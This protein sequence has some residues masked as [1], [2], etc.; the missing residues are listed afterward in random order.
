MVQFDSLTDMLQ[1]AGSANKSITFIYDEKEEKTVLYRQLYSNAVRMLFYLQS[2]GIG[3]GQEVIL[4][5]NDNEIFL[6]VFW[7]CILGGIIPV[8]VSPVVNDEQKQKLFRIW[9]ILEDPYVFADE[10]V[11]D[12]LLK[13]KADY[14]ME[15]IDAIK[16]KTIYSE[17]A[18]LVTGAGIIYKPLPEDIAFI[19]FSSGSTGN[20]KGVVLTHRNLLVN[21]EDMSKAWNDNTEDSILSWMPLTHDMGMITF[22]IRAI[23]AG[24]N[25]YLIPTSLFIRKPLLW[26]DKVHEHRITI[27]SSPNFGYKY[28]LLHYNQAKNLNTW[29]LSCLRI[30]LNGAEPI[31]AC[32]CEEFMRKMEVYGLKCNSMTP[33]YGLAEATVGVSSNRP[34]EGLSVIYANRKF[35]G[36]GQKIKQT[37]ACNSNS[38][39][40][41]DVGQPF[42]NCQVRI[43]DDRNRVL[44]D[45]Y[46]GYI[47]I[48]GPNVTSGYY[49]NMDATESAIKD[50]WLNTGDLGFVR[51]GRLTITGRAKDIIIINGQNYYPHDIERVAENVKGI[52]LGKIVACG[53]FD[54]NTQKEEVFLFVLHKKGLEKFIPIA[55]EVKK[56]VNRIFGIDIKEVIPIKKIFKTTSGKVQ[57]Y[58]LAEMYSKGAFTGIIQEMDRLKASIAGNRET[59][60]PETN[61]EK[62][63][64]KIWQAVLK[65][66]DIGINENLFEIGG[67]SISVIS[68]AARIHQQFGV[69]IPVGRMF[70]IVTIRSQAE[71]IEASG[72]NSYV[73]IKKAVKRE[74]YP[75]SAAQKGMFI[76]QKLDEESIACNITFA[77]KI[78]GSLEKS[79]LENALKKLVERHE[80]LRTSFEIRDEEMVQIIHESAQLEITYT[81]L[82]TEDES[83]FLQAFIKPFDLSSFPLLKVYII[84][85]SDLS[86]LLLIDTHHII[87]DGISI[88]IIQNEII[89]LYQGMELPELKMQYRDFSEWHN[90]LLSSDVIKKQRKYW[91]DQFSGY[92]PVLNLPMDYARPPRKSNE[93]KRLLFEACEELTGRIYSAMSATGTT[94]NMFLL[95]AYFIL[96]SRYS[97]QEDIIIGIAL[98]GRRQPELEKLVGMFVNVLPLRGFPKRNMPF[99]DFLLSIKFSALNAYENQDYPLEE[100]VRDLSPARNLSRNPLFDVGFTVQSIGMDEKKSEGLKFTQYILD[101][102]ISKCDLD[103]MAIE[104]GSRIR[105]ILDYCTRLFKAESME[106]LSQDYLGILEQI[107]KDQSIEIKDIA[108]KNEYKT[109]KK[110]IKDEVEF[111]F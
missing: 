105:F 23:L 27:T 26:I 89:F 18:S 71:Y 10:K 5:V 9:T 83:E 102:R 35:L 55:C 61:I 15:L 38:I 52:E 21:T 63:L 64:L 111:A 97:G 58:R 65:K 93:G 47:Q 106:T 25:Q 74:Y 30:I 100:L 60:E 39:S 78:E 44:Q 8:P 99:K 12:A 29:D 51:N 109:T 49:K 57:R 28:F 41:V 73:P 4:Q 40:F 70:E 36:I 34:G 59:D 91:L 77:L 11:L 92:I 31:S 98:S 33:A 54:E 86:H 101:N 24:M 94:L 1:Y 14:D 66:T 7:A 2:K 68:I 110:T 43:C 67:Q 45:D 85:L 87:V 22:H 80:S 104:D 19:Q 42:E 17:D 16:A 75:V 20:P 48:K 32:L 96:L 13:T 76:A 88:D 46:I 95:A 6:S 81:Q 72:Y 107:A 79:R 3:K 69:D 53:V 82:V 84:K 103:L 56:T 50:G 62:E 90:E 108:I 37:D